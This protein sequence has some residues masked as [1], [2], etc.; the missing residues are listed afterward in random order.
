MSIPA[1]TTKK[2]AVFPSSVIGNQKWRDITK[3]QRAENH[4]AILAKYKYKHQQ[5][6]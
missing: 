6:T 1:L 2:G 3:I 5:K 4:D